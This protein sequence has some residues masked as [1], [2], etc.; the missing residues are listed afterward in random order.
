M[1]EE[2]KKDAYELNL[3]QIV[4]SH[5]ILLHTKKFSQNYVNNGKEVVCAT[6]H[7]VV[8]GELDI[9]NEISPQALVKLITAGKVQSYSTADWISPNILVDS[10]NMLMWYQP[11]MLRTL[12]LKSPLE[13]NQQRLRVNFPSTLFVFER[14]TR[15]LQ[16]L[17]LDS[18]K[19]PTLDSTLYQLPI[20]NISSNGSLCLGNTRDLIPDTPN[21]ENCHLIE[22][23][24]FDALSTHTNTEYLFTKDKEEKK[25]TLFTQVVK[26]WAKKA[27]KSHRV[28]VKKDLIPLFSIRTLLRG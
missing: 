16:I 1:L 21:A 4:T 9:G 15:H 11:T 2:I 20:G 24:F 26:Y 5:A 6:L 13:N 23:C 12:F 14:N 18:D 25:R 3:S 28:N 27:K 22:R 8:G 10:A 17:G 7:D 19:R